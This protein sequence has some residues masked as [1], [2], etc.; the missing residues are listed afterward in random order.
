M[1]SR[2]Y[3]FRLLTD[4]EKRKKVKKKRKVEIE[5]KK[6][7]KERET[8]PN[9]GGEEKRNIIYRACKRREVNGIEF[10]LGFI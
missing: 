4:G 8:Y 9:F 5:K 3:D 2:D 7:K 6:G 10:T 1:L